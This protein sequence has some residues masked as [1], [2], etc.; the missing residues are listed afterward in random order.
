MN[1]QFRKR[2]LLLIDDDDIFVAIAKR[3]IEKAGILENFDVFSDGEGAISFLKDHITDPESIPDFILL[4]INMPYMD[5]WQFLEEYSLFEG[6]LLKKPIIYMI[7]SSVDDADIKKAKDIPYVRDYLIKP[8]SA[9]SF[10]RIL[11]FSEE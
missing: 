10:R 9:D 2:R 11:S 4:D 7:S 6:M 1:S 5:G 3:T 8:V